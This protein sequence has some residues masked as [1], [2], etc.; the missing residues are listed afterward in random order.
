MT[1]REWLAQF[2]HEDHGKAAVEALDDLGRLSGR[3]R[4]LLLPIVTEAI[5]M[6]RR[7]AVSLVER[8][9]P[10]SMIFNGETSL[11][12]RAK[13]LE[14]TFALGDGRR[15]SWAEATVPDHRERIA[16]LE[17]HMR[18]VMMTVSRHSEAIEAIE[19]AGVSC[20]AEIGVAA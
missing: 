20:L 15:V 12:Q 11:G 2:D 6:E 7:K 13:R 9:V 18:G 3:A 17:V 4:E 8:S 1:Y 16:Y 19:A 14:Q 5:L 10:V